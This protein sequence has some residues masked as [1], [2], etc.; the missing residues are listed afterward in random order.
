MEWPA[1][2]GFG[3]GYTRGFTA[4]CI[5]GKVAFAD[6][7]GSERGGK[8]AS[9]ALP[10]NP[11]AVKLHL[12]DFLRSEWRKTGIC[13]VNADCIG[14]KVA[15]ARFPPLR[16]EESWHLKLYRPS[17]PRYYAICKISFPL[18]GGKRANAFFCLFLHLG[19]V[20]GP[21]F[22]PRNDGWACII[23]V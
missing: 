13:I 8:L 21:G 17:I 18:G 4:A 20:T 23:N 11:S 22:D 6:L 19:W 5:G 15:F 3:C 12:P 7:L 14:G 10:P 9:A 2:N 16:Q 1:W